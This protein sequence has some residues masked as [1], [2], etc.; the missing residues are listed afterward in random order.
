MA[1]D[2][3]PCH[4][5]IDKEGNWYYQ[6][7]PIINKEIYLHL[8]K[9]LKKDPSGK[10]VLLM[11][12]E[13]CY[14]EVEDTPYVI[15][16]VC[17]GSATK[18][19]PSLFV[20]LN[21]GTEEELRVDTLRVGKDDVLYCKVKDAQYDA[22]FLRASYYQLAKFLQYDGERY[23]LL[24]EGKKTYPQHINPFRHRKP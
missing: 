14:L 6:D 8:N 12:G 7:L 23:Y 13:K 17:L 15:Q 11:N 4:I 1:E 24:V 3:P 20:R 21:D 9:C 18:R 2:I 10:Y 19:N 16:E 5:R 22:R